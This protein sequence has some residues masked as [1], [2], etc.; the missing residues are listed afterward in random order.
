MNSRATLVDTGPIVGLLNQRDQ[1]HETAKQL[2]SKVVSPLFT[3]WCVITEA[4]WLLRKNSD[5]VNAL[6][7]LVISGNLIPIDLDALACKRIRDI[8]ANYLSLGIQLADASLIYLAEQLN[9]TSILTF[10]FRDFGTV[11][12]E[13]GR[14]FDLP[15]AE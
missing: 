10:D 15:R 1:Q 3:S 5:A 2:F 8:M 4:A 12:L 13:D 7:E 6:L 14:P 11:R 9:T